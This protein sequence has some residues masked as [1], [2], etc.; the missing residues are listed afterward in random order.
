MRLILILC[1]LFYSSFHASAQNHPNSDLSISIES[2][3][4]IDCL[5]DRGEVLV[6]A[7]GGTAP[8]HF[9]WSNGQTG[10][11]CLNL[12]PGIYDVTVTDDVDDKLSISVEIFENFD[13]PDADAGA[14]FSVTCNNA[15]V[16][17][18]GS[19]SLGAQY[20]YFWTASNGGIIQSGATTLT[21]VVRHAGAYKLTVTNISNGCDASSTVNVAADF[22]AP[23]P[24]ATGGAITCGQPQLTLGATLPPHTVFVWNGPNG[25]VSNLLHP[26]VNM[27]GTFVF[28]VT[29]TLTTCINS[30]N[31][32]VAADTMKPLFPLTG[33]V[34]TCVQ[35]TVT[36]T[37]N[38]LPA[39]VN[40]SWKGPFGFTSTLE[41]PVV[42][43]A[44]TYSVTV[45]NPGNSCSSTHS[46]AVTSN[47]TP[48]T[49]TANAVG[50][51]TCI[52]NTVQLM[53]NGSPA[54]I[55]YKWAGPGGF[56]STQ[57]NPIVSAPGTYQL[58][59]TNPQNGC[60]NTAT[61]I[62]Q[63]NTT[64]PGATASGGVRTC[65][66]P[67][68]T[69]QASSNTPGVTYRWAGPSGFNST[70]QNPTV[71]TVGTYTVTVTNPANGCTSTGT[72]SVTQNITP[73]NLTVTS[74]VISCNTPMPHL[75]ANSQTNGATF[76]WSGPNGFSSN[77]SNPVVVTSGSY[78]VTATNPAN[79]CTTSYSVYVSEN[80][81]TPNVYAG[82]DR[83]LNCNF[84]SILANPIGTSTGN[85][86]T[87]LWTT[88]D[89]HIFSGATTLYA[90]FDLPGH[91]T[92]T[93][94]NTQSGCSVQDSM[95]VT[96][97]P[98]LVA[99]ATQ[100]NGVSCNGDSNGSV[101]ANPA[102]GAWPFN[103]HWSTGATSA[104]VNNLGAGTYFVTVTD[105][106]GCSASSSVTVTQPGPLVAN[107][108]ATGQTQMGMNN[109]TA[110]VTP[111]GGSAPY[112]VKWSNNATSLTIGG[113]APGQ[114]TVTVT[115]AH[116]CTK[117]NTA[118]VNPVNCSIAGTTSV[119]NLV[120]AGSNTGSATVTVT[121]A[122]GP[123]TYQWSNGMQSQTINNLAAGNYTVTVSSGAG[124][125][126]VISAQVTTPQPVSVVV[127]SQN[128]PTCA[129]A[130]NGS[131]SVTA[132]G[133][134]GQYTFHWSNGVNSASISNIA[135]GSYTCTVTDGSGCTQ[136]TSV[137]LSNP[138]SVALAV[139]GII[140]VV[141]ANDLT[142]SATMQ[143]TGGSAPYVFTWS[144]N[145]A[146]PTA[147]GIG[148]GVYTCTVTDVNGCT[149][150][151]TAQIVTTDHNPPHLILKN[152]TI[153]LNADG[154]A[155]L[156]PAM[157]DNGSSDAECDIASWSVNPSS[158][159]CNDI[160]THVVTL[161]ALDESGNSATGTAVV[162]I[163][164]NMMPMLICPANQ[165]VSSCTPHVTFSQ[166]IVEDNCSA[167]GGAVLVA[168]LPSGSTFPQGVTQEQFSFT[169][170]G[171]NTATCQFTITVGNGLTANISTTGATCSGNCDG[172]AVLSVQN[173]SASNILWSN[174]QS[175][176]SVFNLCS[177]SYTATVTDISGCTQVFSASVSVNDTQTPLV[178]CPPSQ[179]AGFCNATVIFQTPQVLDN[180][181]VN[182]QQVQL[183]AGLPSGS[184]FP[185]GVTNEVFRY[186]DSGGNFGECSFTITVHAMPQVFINTTAPTCDGVCNGAAVI[187][188][189]GSNSSFGALWN[190]GFAGANPVNLCAGSYS[191]TVIDGDGCPQIKTGTLTGP[192]P[193]EISN[194]L[195]IPDVGSIGSGS[196]HISVTGGTSP[197]SYLWSRNGLPFSTVQ[198]L[199]HLFPGNYSVTIND[200]NGCSFISPVFQVNSSV[201]TKEPGAAAGWYCYPVPAQ[202]QLYLNLG[203]GWTSETSV[204]IFDLS[205]RKVFELTSAPAALEKS[206]LDVSRLPAGGYIL[207][208]SDGQKTSSKPVIV[209]R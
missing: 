79:G 75:V 49:A 157:F 47:T 205:G 63:L 137:Q 40:F 185:V 64:P 112:T 119:T 209:S 94:K 21:P 19:G 145:A 165:S 98:P 28:K 69:L 46:V 201:S 104:Q 60:T 82:E 200:A 108:S 198:D 138:Q 189:S 71:T 56:I 128:N 177:G 27:P 146:G 18:N 2:I 166:P 54:G 29:D 202:S 57:Q 16:S 204:A 10:P 194:S 115:D 143:A 181:P 105:G 12:D 14:D 122:G 22:D 25:Y 3:Q 171:G 158:F 129:G 167:D 131:I 188:L 182:Q 13:L 139:T 88:W 160:G 43:A 62:A 154:I 117:S 111:S 178:I 141:C 91:Y 126:A 124:C 195:V 142:G 48:P 125:S 140:N 76:S 23:E 73:P 20:H 5:H 132:S 89:G 121:G 93:V 39:G 77:I 81:D 55:T 197:Y 134:S 1:L 36:I 187:S 149:T 80:L 86:I 190:N 118:V 9:E 114:Y 191:V 72:A 135:A 110:T 193:I 50:A 136:T 163:A 176:A 51:I 172:S 58:T 7:D 17:L 42:S 101:K 61:A 4:H 159:H 169:D 100:L 174:G 207:R 31:A 183:L 184:V 44:G 66:S 156:L 208:I 147:S 11:I 155:S 203:A 106:E 170:A 206:P 130:Q 84:S 123:V 186:T 74:A 102:G 30:A 90:R 153:S 67:T 164:D 179:T 38:A 59:T 96:Q 196:I 151:Q 87:Y 70:L 95:E 97:T 65:I 99:N 52:S 41:N 116:G 113:L 15:I 33:G 150:S 32:V 103:F 26:Q 199:D 45:T 78:T 175:G 144:N 162:T 107:V 92:L 8:Y 127:V 133:G 180:C 148:A 192:Q 152:A 109:G 53:G 168:G 83:S 34:L 35:N 68:V 24:S 6:S 85:N 161:T 37:G 173:G 120:C